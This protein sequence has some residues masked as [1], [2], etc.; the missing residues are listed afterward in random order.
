MG[1]GKLPMTRAASCS[2]PNCQHIGAV[3]N[4]H[5]KGNEALW[6]GVLKHRK[7]EATYRA[8]LR[9]YYQYRKEDCVD[10]CRLHHAEI[11]E[12]YDEITAEDQAGRQKKSLRDYSWEEAAE[13]SL[14]LAVACHEWLKKE[15]PGIDS[16]LYGKRKKGRRNRLL[17]KAEGKR[18]AKKQ[19][20]H[21][22]QKRTW[23]RKRNS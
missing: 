3:L 4:R 12:I 10:L 1:K 15:T 13:L 9:R 2:K 23:R 8:L 16:Y 14:K 5:H 22:R 20:E 7:D 17:K 11:H 18:K 21:E 6:L 19:K